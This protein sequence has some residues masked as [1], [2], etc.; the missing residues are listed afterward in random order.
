[1]K[2]FLTLLLLL[3]LFLVGCQSESAT[4]DNGGSGGAVEQ[5][6]E[7]VAQ[8]GSAAPAFT[9]TTDRG[10]RLTLESLRGGPVVLNFWA[11]W[12]PPCR[13]EM[14]ELQA[15]YE[16]W[17][18]KGLTMIGVEVDS[19]GNLAESANFLAEAGVTFPVTRDLGAKLEGAYLLRNALP[20]TVIID[21]EGNVAYIH[22]GA[23]T[24]PFLNDKLIELGF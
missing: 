11:T 4:N 6:G 8:V 12:C 24:Q 20:T 9:L 1:M 7:G 19:S 3:L 14:P 16:E 2:R 10:E 22:S 5:V 15:L 13:L 17:Q 21:G 23:I 18:P